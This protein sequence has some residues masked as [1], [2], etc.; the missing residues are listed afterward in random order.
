MITQ[1][2][3]LPLLVLT[4]HH[5]LPTTHAQ[6]SNPS[7]DADAII[8]TDAIYNGCSYPACASPSGTEY[9]C[10]H[11]ER[12]C[13]DD[14]SFVPASQVSCS[15]TDI[16]GYPS[17][18]G[19]C[20]ASGYFLPMVREEDCVGGTP[21]CESESMDGG[22]VPTFLVG[23]KS[24]PFSACD[25]QCGFEFDHEAVVPEETYHGCKFPKFEW[26][27][28][29]S[30]PFGSMRAHQL[31]ILGDTLHV[32]G[33]LW[34][35]DTSDN[36][37]TP[38]TFDFQL[39][40]PYTADDPTA[41][42]N[43]KRIYERVQEYEEERSFECAIATIDKVTGEPKGVLPLVGPGACYINAM[44][45]DK[46]GTVLVAGGHHAAKGELTVPT[47]LC[48]PGSFTSCSD[49]GHTTIRA[50]DA[51]ATAHVFYTNAE[52]IVRWL[53][54]PWVNFASYESSIT[55][56]SVDDTGDVYLTGYRA[57]TEGDDVVYT[58]MLTK[59]S[60]VDGSVMWEKMLVGA[61]HTLH[62]AY[63]S[64]SD[65]LFVTAEVLAG[66]EVE[67]LGI[68][69]IPEDERVE[70]CNV[71]MR[72]G[73][74]DGKV[75]WV[76]YAYGYLGSPEN[77]GDVQLAHKKD[78]DYVY[79]SFNGVGTHGPTSLDHGTPY[80][81]CKS[82]IGG[83]SIPEF[84]DFFTDP[85]TANFFP[86]PNEEITEATCATLTAFG[87]GEFT[88]VSRTSEDAIPAYAAQSLAT[89]GGYGAVNCLVKYHKLTGKPKW[90][91]VKPRIFG[92]KPQRNGIIVVGSNFGPVTLDT[93]TVAGP[94]GAVDG[95]DMVFQSKL[96]LDGQGLYVQPIIADR[97][98]VSGAGL[99][100]D[101][102]TNKIYLGFFTTSDHTYLGP[103][104]PGGFTQDLELD[105]CK[106]TDAVCEGEARMTVAL[107][108][109]PTQAS[110]IDSCDNF[111]GNHTIS[112]GHCYIDQICYEDGDTAARIGMPCMTC[113]STTSQTEWSEATTIGVDFCLI[114]NVCY[115]D[116]APLTMR[117]VESTT[118]ELIASECQ[119]CTPTE[120]ATSWTLKERYIFVEEE[121]PPLDCIKTTIAPSS[122]SPTKAPFFVLP[123]RPPTV[124]RTRSPTNPPPPPT[125]APTNRA[126]FSPITSFTPLDTTKSPSSETDD[127]DDNTTSAA[128]PFNE[129]VLISGILASA[130]VLM[131]T[132]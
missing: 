73:A 16:L 94:I 61:K 58:A 120:N 97:S 41:S 125:L 108:G 7:C 12:F 20:N 18:I 54:Q 21:I 122:S 26:T 15:C 69:C 45:K 74:E 68:T 116:G 99:T 53:I 92:F 82:E 23:Y 70:G 118:S 117:V 88:Y 29:S 42:I 84:A 110:C 95:Y 2:L 90:G 36:T 126:T 19:V 46:G 119:V 33:S 127:N 62:S 30:G 75:H 50:P 27:T 64:D 104:S 79:A 124:P 65:A 129:N 76:R 37:T 60:G 100:E 80:S 22:G 25:L 83:P 35:F 103:G 28:A 63:D 107:L 56:I 112:T 44:G 31:E 39:E 87:M 131:T 89:C 111:E 24:S 49:E 11:D 14:E 105:T 115:R 57:I 1:S 93:T 55:G 98:S 59:L 77:V 72:V 67:L 8:S 10:V 102:E 121:D 132:V 43:G 106:I 81:H 13:T 6:Q 52:G 9:R 109:N 86:N 47:T 4:L 128:C 3:P 78:G 66:K 85:N 34:T 123:P 38:V 48:T 71:L 101:P 91:S 113:D 40:G 130:F 96:D 114:D 17:T 32:G 51:V 5:T